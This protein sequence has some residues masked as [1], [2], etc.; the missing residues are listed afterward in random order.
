MSS[1]SVDYDWVEVDPG[2]SPTAPD[3]FVAI[4]RWADGEV[5]ERVADF[6]G[7]DRFVNADRFLDALRETGARV[8]APIL[9][10][11]RRE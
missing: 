3:G 4:E 6:Y 8:A 7:P 2:V 9:V 11:R 10:G 1:Q 5:V